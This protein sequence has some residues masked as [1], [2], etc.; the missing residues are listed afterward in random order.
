MD[1]ATKRI[2][3]TIVGGSVLLVVVIM[4]IFWLQIIEGNAYADEASSQQERTQELKARRGA[5]FAHEKGEL[6]PLAQTKEGWTVSIDPRLIE[7]D[8][9]AY[10]A[11][12]EVVG[13]L[14]KGDF[15]ER[16]A[17]KDDPHEI[18]VDFVP[19]SKKEEIEKKKIRGVY[20]SR[21]SAR[22][23][24]AESRAAHVLGFADTE[25]KGQYG[26]E[27][28]YHYDLVGED[29]VFVGETTPAGR[30]LHLGSAI[31]QPEKN[32][33]DMVLTMDMGMQIYL[34]ETVKNIYQRYGA[35]NAGGMIV[36]PKTGAIIAMTATPTFNP[37]SY[38]DTK[39]L[40]VFQNP[41]VEK[42]YEMGS[43][44]K[45]LTMAA[46]LDVGAVKPD[47]WYFDQGRMVIDTEVVSNF[48]GKGRGNVPI[49]E[50]LSQ[51]LNTGAVHLM[52]TMGRDRFR[53]YFH[54]FALDTLTNV[55]LPNEVEGNVDNLES[56]RT[57]EYATAS[58]GQGISTTPV[59]LVRA[60]GSIA[61]G[62]LLVDPYLVEEIRYASG[63]RVTK[64][65]GIQTRVI[66]EE[67]ART[68][69]RMMVE[70]VD[71]RL[72]PLGNSVP[73]YSV[74]AKTGTAQIARVGASGY[75]GKYL[76]TLV[77]FGPAY[78]AQFLVFLF[79]EE[80]QGVRYSSETLI[81]PFRDTMQKLFS[82]FEVPPD[83]PQE[84]E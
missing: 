52:N 79:V 37:N 27:Q 49:Q 20:F 78:D 75:S 83:R 67:T 51:S 54:K 56:S 9:A 71:V 23:Y 36:N 2:W 15:L 82:Y 46:A 10:E 45:P 41:H 77:G 17:K 32:G 76:H 42:L 64:K 12:Y 61:N 72:K 47:D 39:N 73:G 34:E 3:I 26:L 69:S 28:F 66:R 29:G 63:A 65:K 7:D 60:L 68:V 58:F 50:V 24:P 25:G 53:D 35:A 6:V 48:D 5:I 74:A 31:V 40:G 8:L 44:I 43:V 59:A 38:K 30:F 80:P 57:I 33:V 21:K 1:I 4:R 81:R 55:D 16:A 22:T 11:I 19:T 84:L 14:E 13:E 70:L 18:V 62:G